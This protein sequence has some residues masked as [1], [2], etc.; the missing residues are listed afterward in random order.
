MYVIN[1]EKKP[2]GNQFTVN[3]KYSPFLKDKNICKIVLTTSK[4]Q[5]TKLLKAKHT[6]SG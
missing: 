4:L 3:G 6:L 5:A 1:Y 2:D